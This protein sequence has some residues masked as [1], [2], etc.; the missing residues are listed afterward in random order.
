MKFIKNMW[1]I[2]IGVIILISVVIYYVIFNGS[3]QVFDYD[4]TEQ[5]VRFVLHGYRL[6]HR[7][8]FPLWDWS[9]FLGANIFSHGFYFLFSPFW[10]LF[11][12]LPEISSVP[13]AFLYINILK[14]ILLF[15]TSYIYFS[16]I[17]KTKLSAFVGSCII[18]FSGFALG[19]Y[20]YSH[21]VDILLF[22]PLVLYFIEK[23]LKNGTFIGFVLTIMIMAIINGY[24]L[25]FFTIYF[26]I[27]AIF[28]Y[29]M[30]NKKF[31][32]NDFLIVGGKFFL[33]YLLG[34]GLSSLIFIPTISTMLGSPRLGLDINLFNTIN[35]YDLFRYITGF[36]SPIVDRNNFNP[37]VNVQIVPSYGWSGGAA[38][39]S[40]IITPLLLTQIFVFKMSVKHRIILI[41]ALGLLIIFSL[42]PSLYLLLNGSNDTRWMVM[43]TLFLSY[44]VTIFIDD[45][46]LIHIPTLLLTTLGLIF[47]FLISFYLTERFNLQPNQNYIDIAI[48]N[49]YV[50]IV[51]LL[52]YMISIVFFRSKKYF[53][54]FFVFIVVFEN[55]LSLYN[56]FLNPVDSISMTQEKLEGYEL[57]NTDIIDYI[58]SID[59]SAY[60]ISSNENAGFN[61]PMS[62][63]Y[64]GF[65]FYTSVYNYE[66]NDFLVNNLSS[67]GGWVVGSNPGKWQFKNMFGAKYW[68]DTQ[69]MFDPAYGYEYIKTIAY[70]DKNIDIYRNKYPV[71]LIY[72]MENELSLTKWLELDGLHKLHSLMS[73]VVTEDSTET[74]VIYPNTLF[75]IQDFSTHLDYTF[76]TLQSHAIVYASFPRSEEV[77]ISLYLDDQLIETHYSYEPQYSSLYSTQFFNRI[78]ID[79]TNLYGVPESEF[80]NTAYIEYPNETYPIWY[81][82]LLN[83]A[84]TDVVLGTNTFSG[85]INLEDAKWIVTSIAFDPN[86]TIYVNDKK[87][88]FEKVNGGFIGFKGIRGE[89]N[90]NAYY[91]PKVLI[92]SFIISTISFIIFVILYLKGKRK[93]SVSTL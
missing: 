56:I 31:N 74:E 26:F 68:Y 85:S 49:S 55:Y 33:F 63:D 1:P 54:L 5:G 87:V 88:E 73:M 77:T 37:F 86:W 28:R 18:T 25:Y 45:L 6:I 35:R 57:T 82:N 84:S 60:R 4:M 21:F 72:S 69:L 32:L 8:E 27:Y 47:S 23:Y 36:L 64:M 17:R 83:E 10:L 61:N 13:Y 52:M 42:F 38:V 44:L 76:D 24:F 70:D 89:N 29:L 41:S 78:V 30:F 2:L 90:I 50:L 48:R 51:I 62:K 93:S 22:V 91:F 16:Y 53:I 92:L 80:I 34:L 7:L 11:N 43:F 19:Y 20:N 59:S 65:T 12:L 71:P 79:V 46:D 14:Q 3:V 15:V 66:M 39:Y 81:D 40:L 58:K 9:H 75:K 67:A